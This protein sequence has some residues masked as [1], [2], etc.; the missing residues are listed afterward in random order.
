MV[1]LLNY[2]RKLII[3][4]TAHHYLCLQNIENSH[5]KPFLH[6]QPSLPFHHQIR[7]PLLLFR[8]CSENLVEYLR[9]RDR[10]KSKMKK[11]SS[12]YYV[13]TTTR[14]WMN[15]PDLMTS[16]SIVKAAGVVGTCNSLVC[17]AN[18]SKRYHSKYNFI[19]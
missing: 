17:L 9:V 7:P 12:T 3:S 5:P 16:L 13:G 15:T 8:L 19:L 6:F 1:N 10:S 11:K 4:C 2:W 14:I 18:D